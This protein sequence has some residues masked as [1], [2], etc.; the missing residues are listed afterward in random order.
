MFMC[1]TTKSN[2]NKTAPW[3]PVYSSTRIALLQKKSLIF[4]KQLIFTLFRQLL[5]LIICTLWLLMPICSTLFSWLLCYC[6]TQTKQKW[7]CSRGMHNIF[8]DNDHH[9][10]THTPFAHRHFAEH[11]HSTKSE[12]MKRKATTTIYV[13]WRDDV[14]KVTKKEHSKMKMKMNFNRIVCKRDCNQTRCEWLPILLFRW[15]RKITISD[16][17]AK[18]N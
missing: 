1:K 10:C 9:T 4:I 8:N 6:Y 15:S 2:W 17:D 16:N 13:I 3:H 14:P 12:K 7:H 11:R 18:M 5:L